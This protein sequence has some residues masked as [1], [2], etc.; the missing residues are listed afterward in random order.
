MD[1]A[2]LSYPSCRVRLVR[3]HCFVSQ[4]QSRTADHYTDLLQYDGSSVVDGG[5]WMVDGLI[6]RPSLVSHSP[7]VC[8][9][10]ALGLQR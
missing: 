9:R 5:W 4:Q 1:G 8:R 10:V 7:A 3:S 2:V 6:C